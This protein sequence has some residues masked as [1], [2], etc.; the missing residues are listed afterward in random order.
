MTSLLST[1]GYKFSMA[2]AGF[3]L[4][5]ETFYY[6]HR[7][8]GPQ[9]VPFDVAAEIERLVPTPTAADYTYLATHEYEMGAG[10]KA[11][12]RVAAP[13]L[14]LEV[15]AL[16][17]G[18]WFVP[19]EPV[20]TVTGPSALVSWLEPLVLM[21]HF[22]IQ[23]ATLALTDRDA[24]GRAVA[25]V[26]CDEERELIEVTLAAVGVPAPPMRV[27]REAY[28]ERVRARAAELVQITQTPMRVFEVGMRA[29][30]CVAQHR[31]ALTACRDAGFTRTSHVALAAELDMVPIGTMGHEH[32]QRFGSDDA[33][34]RAMRDRRPGRSSYLLDTFDT[35]RSGLPTALA[36]MEET[37]GCGDSIRYDS[38]DKEAQYR[39]AVGE[40]KK[41]NVR[42]V[43]I[44]EDSFDAAQTRH[45]ESLRAELGVAAEEQFYGFGGY[46]VASPAPSTLT[47]DRVAAVYKLSQ[48]GRGPAMKFGNE[49]G[50][51]KESIPGEPVVFRRSDAS[52]N[53]PA[54]IVG[55]RGE[56]APAGYVQITGA[57]SGSDAARVAQARPVSEGFALSAATAALAATL[58]AR[59]DA[60]LAGGVS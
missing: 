40:A 37:P 34:Y 17:Q 32:V 57:A 54:G 46:L 50:A 52:A 4:R 56:S 30:S 51:G 3:P 27:A 6:T 31:I 35:L 28:A 39:A 15:R 42:P 24:L 12:M 47:R 48:S 19:R 14:R 20:F 45:F 58:R 13:D 21:F 25:Q 7:R 55:Q 43:H 26:T 41:R 2:E 33:A 36:L 5:R 29:A 16:P 60:L 38:G 9:V 18:A 1:D 49:A 11:A 23:V 22:R 10:F 53:A 44:L 8:G 59:K